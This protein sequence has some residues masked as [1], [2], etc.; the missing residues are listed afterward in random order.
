MYPK[1][2]LLASPEMMQVRQMAAQFAG[3][4]G[5]ARPASAAPS[6][7]R[8]PVEWPSSV[9]ATAP[10]MSKLHQQQQ[11]LGPRGSVSAGALGQ[12]SARDGDLH[13]WR[14]KT[15]V[16]MSSQDQLLV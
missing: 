11:Q 1:Y 3:D 2:R 7:L 5:L 16:G 8:G 12:P 14:G 4:E 6:P 9:P 10:D 15:D 13:A